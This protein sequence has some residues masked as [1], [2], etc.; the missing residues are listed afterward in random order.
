VTGEELEASFFM[1]RT[2]DA[3]EYPEVTEI[4]P[5]EGAECRDRN[6][7]A[8]CV[9]DHVVCT[10]A[11]TQEFEVKNIVYFGFETREDA[12]RF[13]EPGFLISPH[14]EGYD[15]VHASDCVKVCQ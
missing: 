9:G 10:A 5:P 11:T 4:D 12:V 8:I 14:E 6:G 7:D 2:G 13:S 3:D 15:L 1:Y